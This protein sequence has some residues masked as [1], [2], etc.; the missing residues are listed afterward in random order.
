MLCGVGRT[1]S[2]FDPLGFTL[3]PKYMAASTNFVRLSCR[4][5]GIDV[6][7]GVDVDVQQTATSW[8][9]AVRLFVMVLLLSF[10]FG[11]EKCHAPTSWL[12]LYV[13]Q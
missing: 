1:S 8:H 9:M 6:D 3:S 4:E 10:W 13:Q 2:T 11:S 5:I 7:V 12:L